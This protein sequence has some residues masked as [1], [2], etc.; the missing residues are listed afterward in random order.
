MAQAFVTQASP[1][2]A[3]HEVLETLAKHILAAVVDG[4]HERMPAAISALQ[5]AVTAHLDDEE[6]EVVPRYAQHD[7][8]DAACI[9]AEH[10]DFRRVLAALDLETDLHLVR[11]EAMSSFLA[12]LQ[13]HAAREDAGMYRWGSADA[14]AAAFV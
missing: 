8:G 12:A 10:A 4:D 11:A 7:P 14:A 9:L 5:A 2:R 13:A 1:I 3:D 6:R